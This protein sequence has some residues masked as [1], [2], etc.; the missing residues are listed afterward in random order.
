MNK[1]KNSYQLKVIGAGLPRTGTM[2]MKHALEILGFGKCY[3]M[4]ENFYDRKFS[5]RSFTNLVRN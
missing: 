1:N 2:S 4:I 5:A 3:H